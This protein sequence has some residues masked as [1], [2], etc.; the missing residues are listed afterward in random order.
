MADQERRVPALTDDERAL[1][2]AFVREYRRQN[3]DAEYYTG[4][5]AMNCAAAICRGAQAQSEA[6]NLYLLKAAM[7]R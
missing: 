4:H 7:R 3:P 6:W 2:P 1:W 5:Y